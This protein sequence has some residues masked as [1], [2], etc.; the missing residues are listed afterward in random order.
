MYKRQALSYADSALFCLNAHYKQYSHQTAPLLRLEGEGTAA[1]LEWFNNHFDTDYYTLLDVR[2]ESAVA[3]LALGHLDAYR[4]NN[5]A[6][7]ALYKQI[8]E[9][10]SLEEYCRQ[11]QL[12]ANNKIVAIILC[13]VI[14]L[15]LLTGYYLL[16]FRHRLL[17]RYNLEQVLEINQQVFTGSLLNEQADKDI[18]ESLVNAMFEGINELIAIDVLGI[19]VYSEDS[20]NLKCS[21]SLSD[22]GNEDMRELMTRCFETQTVYWTEKNRIKC[23]P[24]WVETGGENRCT[25]VLALRCSFDSEREDDRLMVELV[26]GYVAIIAYN[27]VVLMAQKY[28]DIETAQDDARRAI[29]EENQL[30]VQNLVLDN[31]LSTIKHETI[32]YPNKIKQII[33]KLNNE[34]VR[35]NE[36]RQIELSL[37]HI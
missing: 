5:N 6:Y 34:P 32:Y 4:Y 27:A 28:R 19:A 29:R 15:L 7:T 12:S 14:L 18:A 13:I 21:F 35:E 16:Y 22:E 8:S 20:H 17:Y 9:D 36:R 37:I 33:D 25:G 3:F 24:L 1:E 11:M 26:A 23:L 31:C 2:N 10:T 30:H